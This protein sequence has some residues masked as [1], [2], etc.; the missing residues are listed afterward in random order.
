[1]QSEVSFDIGN[2]TEDEMDLYSPP[3]ETQSS[4]FSEKGKLPFS[5]SKSMIS[6]S[7]RLGI[8]WVWGIGIII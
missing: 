2:E 8:N 6:T 7:S 3:V 5:G 4:A 1:M